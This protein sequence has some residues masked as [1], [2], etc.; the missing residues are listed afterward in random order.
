MNLTSYLPV[1]IR[2]L[3]VSVMAAIAT[4]G[5][6]STEQNA[7]LTQNLDIIVSSVVGL[8][9]V[10]Y[11]LFKRPSSKAMEV[12]KQVDKKVPAAAPVVIQTPAGEPDIVVQAKQ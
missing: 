4:R 5:W 12:A 6:V 2:Y 7:I 1:I 8:L 10:A 3:I 11:A 9:T